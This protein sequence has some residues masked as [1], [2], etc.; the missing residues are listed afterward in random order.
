PAFTSLTNLPPRSFA[1]GAVTDRGWAPCAVRFPMATKEGISINATKREKMAILL[2]TGITF[3]TSFLKEIFIG[4][5][6]M[7][8]YNNQLSE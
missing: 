1:R 5:S 6:V 3:T 4:R 7:R 8:C 2:C